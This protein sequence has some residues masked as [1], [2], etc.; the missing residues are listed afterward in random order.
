[1]TRTG[2]SIPIPSPLMAGTVALF[3]LACTAGGDKADSASASATGAS[4]SAAKASMAT[5][6]PMGSTEGMKTPESVRYDA[7]LDR[8]YVSNI[9]GNP[10]QKDGNGFIA[11]VNPDSTGSMTMLAEGGKKGVVLNAP[12]GMA[13]SG[14]TIW[15]ADI[16]MV[17]GINR[18]TGAVLANV[19]LRAMKATFL[20]DI[21]IG[22]DGAVYITDTGIAFD[23]KGGMSHPGV[24]R[25]FRLQGGKVT[26]VAKGDSLANPNGIAW[27][28]ANGRFVLAPFGGP[29]VQAWKNGDAAPTSL[30]AGPGQYDGIEVLKDG[31]ILVSS[32]ADSAVH[33]LSAGAMTTIAKGVAAPADIGVDTKRHVLAVPL[34]NDG[35]VQYFRIP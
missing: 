26:E 12:K 18:R 32:W 27:D 24:N 8:W 31:R 22:G 5:A 17:R 9:N 2:R 35:K 3:A 4:D 23:A 33:S 11:V 29:N 1:M 25:I 16:D 6:S 30:G 7:E 10:S 34:F 19:D 15:V 20:N 13:L 14:D 28:A 21:A